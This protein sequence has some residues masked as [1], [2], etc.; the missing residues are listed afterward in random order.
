MREGRNA[1]RVL[2]HSSRDED[3]EVFGI[4]IFPEWSSNWVL[5]IV[6][7]GKGES[8]G[9]G[10][11]GALGGQSCSSPFYRWP[12]WGKRLNQHSQHVRESGFIYVGGIHLLPAQ[13]M[14][15]GRRAVKTKSWS[16]VLSMCEVLFQCFLNRVSQNHQVQSYLL[17]E[18]RKIWALNWMRSNRNMFLCH[19]P[20]CL[21]ERGNEIK[22]GVWN[23]MVSVWSYQLWQHP[24]S[25]PPHTTGS[26]NIWITESSN[27]WKSHRATSWSPS[28]SL[29][30]KRWLLY[31]R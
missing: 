6:H 30:S 15:E 4:Q 13:K 20:Y 21:F 25:W 10:R 16:S 29:H 9:T 24:A 7:Q 31:H 5:Y 12:K 23:E 14:V 2:E 22:G 11:A 28:P 18:H 27:A 3:E 8:R 17:Q 19:G 1:K 26:I